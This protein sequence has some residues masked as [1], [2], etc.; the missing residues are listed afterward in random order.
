[1][2]SYGESVDDIA[3]KLEY[4]LYYME[5]QDFDCI[6]ME[7]DVEMREKLINEHLISII[8]LLYIIVKNIL[9]K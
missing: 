9:K 5:Y 1:M 4:D 2:Y 3:R 7:R 6:F 8:T